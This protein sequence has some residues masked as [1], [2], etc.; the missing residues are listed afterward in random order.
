MGTNPQL[1]SWTFRSPF[2]VNRTG[3]ADASWEGQ[4]PQEASA[5][6]VRERAADA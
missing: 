6:C 3:V 2:G 5:E 4:A 1:G